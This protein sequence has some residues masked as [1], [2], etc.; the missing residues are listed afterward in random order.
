MCVFDYFVFIGSKDN[1]SALVIKLPGAVLGSA[2]NGGVEKVRQMRIE[3]A[4]QQHF[5]AAGSGSGSGYDEFDDGEPPR[6][7]R[8]SDLEDYHHEDDPHGWL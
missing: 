6:T 8:D 3:M 1:V 2:F 7:R 4:L 5:A